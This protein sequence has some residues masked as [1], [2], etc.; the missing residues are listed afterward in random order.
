MSREIFEIVQGMDLKNIETQ[1]ALQCAPLITC[2]RGTP[3]RRVCRNPAW[4]NPQYFSDA[5]SGIYE[6]F[7]NI[8]A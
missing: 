3:R 8:S 4:K 7:K 2:K 1:L 5:L 6:W